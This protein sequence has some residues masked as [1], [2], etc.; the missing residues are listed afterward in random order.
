MGV[1]YGRALVQPTTID[2][3]AREVDVVCATE[4][5]VTRFGW[6]EDY[7]EML[8]CEAGAIR[9]DRA[10]QGLPLLDCH[11]AYT[12]H[13]QL[14]RTVKVWINESRQLCARVRFSSRPEVAGIFQDVVDGIVKGISVGYEIYKFEREERPNGARPI[15]R[16]ID[17]MPSELSLAPVP[18]DIDSGIRAVQQQ[19]PVEIINKR[20]TN[21]T[22]NMKKT[23]A[24][25]TGKTM[26]YVVEGD[27]VKQGDIVT[28]DGVK[29][30]ALSDG[31][32]GDTIT[33][34]LIEEEVTPTDSDEAKTNEDV[35]AAAEDAA[36]AAEDAAAAAKDAAA[37][38]TEATGGTEQTEE[39]R[40][41]T[42]AIQQMA[43]AAGLS[44]DY[45][46]AL[47]GTDLTVE[48]CSTAIMRRL[49][50]R[51]QE[52][53]VNG[54]HSVRATGLDAGT[55]KRMAV[56]NALLHRIY[57]SKF[58]LDAGAREFR[59][60]TMVEIGRE[61]LSERGINTRGLDRS[62]VA[63]MVF[64][65]AH[66]TSDFPLLFEGVINKMLRAQYEFAPEFWDKI[67]RQT[68][69]DD[70]RAR[71]LYS[72]GVANGMKKI[73]EGGEIKYTTLKESKEQIRVETFGEGISYTR[74]AFI[75]DDLGV[76]SIIPS[77]FV[78]HWD[79]L[80]G[81]LVWGLLTDNVKMSDGKGIFDATHGNLLTGASSALSEESL[82]AAKTAM[83]K[84]KDIAGQII[85][86]VPRYLIVSPENEMM[87]KKLVTATTPVKFEDVNVFAG[88]FDVIVEPRLT[89]PKAWYLM[90]DPYAV[91]SLYYAYLEG[92][93]GLRVDSTEEFKT[94][95][96]DY[97]VRGD[98]GAAAIDYRG[99]VK[100]AGK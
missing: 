52:N 73:P 91:D 85:R 70:F 92:N 72:A 6:E 100:A 42:Q 22:T 66:S 51:S 21:T 54:N 98:F 13:S 58:S 55:K 87:A 63:K 57:P 8:V 75:N 53:G 47:V 26:E 49:A 41:R 74:Q 36:A 33:L 5:M 29:G 67:A 28:V 71:G 25:E 83:M 7:D 76:F 65:R 2:Q 56:E 11:N 78:R 9:M 39:N 50:K 96:M 97:A 14:G 30:V 32:V 64:N 59:G 43:R 44:A 88:A 24:T 4:K 15:Y 34:T 81:N 90:A 31:E 40:K 82:A 12:V 79:M 99:I 84:Q 20:I 69:V 1:L 23:R 17:W 77:A 10:N 3:E 46:L 86:M 45:A 60:M 80:R 18:A 48:Q 68:S 16:A 62:E 38:V 61:L 93:E 94:D 37:A 27:P 89:D 95:S 19:H 35:V